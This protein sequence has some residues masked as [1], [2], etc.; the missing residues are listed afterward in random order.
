M[1]QNSSYKTVRY[2]GPLIIK[3]VQKILKYVSHHYFDAYQCV[4]AMDN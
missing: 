4:P 3:D 2:Y 1:T